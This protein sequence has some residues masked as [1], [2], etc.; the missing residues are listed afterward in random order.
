VACKHTHTHPP[1][2][3]SM[4][5]RLLTTCAEGLCVNLI[6]RV[7]AAAATAAMPAS[8]TNLLN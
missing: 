4:P 7:G 3:P 8:T 1:D 5:K 2:L 6:T